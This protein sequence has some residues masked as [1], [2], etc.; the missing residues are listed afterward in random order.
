[1]NDVLCNQLEVGDKVLYSTIGSYL[2]PGLV[3]KQDEYLKDYLWVDGCRCYYK[4]VIKLE[5]N[6]GRND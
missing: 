6:K 5:N 3:E 2:L 1:M 4:T